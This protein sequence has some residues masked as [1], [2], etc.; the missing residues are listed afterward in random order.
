[1]AVRKMTTAFLAKF[2][3]SYGFQRIQKELVHCANTLL[4]GNTMGAR[5]R[6]KEMLT[7]LKEVHSIVTAQAKA[8]GDAEALKPSEAV[9]ATKELT[10]ASEKPAE[11]SPE[12]DDSKEGK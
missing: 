10:K 4:T 3:K 1:M 12:K 9:E 5:V 2:T 8:H 6:R 7:M 11:K